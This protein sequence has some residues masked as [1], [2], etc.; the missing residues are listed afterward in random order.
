MLRIPNLR[1]SSNIDVVAVVLDQR[2]ENVLFSEVESNNAKMKARQFFNEREV[3]DFSK[4][5][6]EEEDIQDNF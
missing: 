6:V 1:K 3:F 2:N 4:T 5:H